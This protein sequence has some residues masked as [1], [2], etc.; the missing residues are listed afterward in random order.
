[1]LNFLLDVAPNGIRRRRKETNSSTKSRQLS[2]TSST[3]DDPFGRKSTLV[4]LDNDYDLP[5]IDVLQLE[6]E[7]FASEQDESESFGIEFACPQGAADSISDH[8]QDFDESQSQSIVFA[9]SGVSDDAVS[10]YQGLYLL[11]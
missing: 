11:Q 4:A 5:A 7:A 6:N 8:I 2:Q 3:A 10:L 9:N 1:M